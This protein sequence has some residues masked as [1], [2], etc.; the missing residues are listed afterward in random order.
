MGECAHTFKASVWK[1]MGG[2]QGT[3][4]VNSHRKCQMKSPLNQWSL[5]LEIDQN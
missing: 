5:S 1:V 4:N 2:T 3:T